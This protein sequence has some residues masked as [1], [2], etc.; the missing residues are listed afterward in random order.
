MKNKEYKLIDLV[1]RGDKHRKEVDPTIIVSDGNSKRGV[2]LDYNTLIDKINLDG[3][4]S[5]NIEFKTSGN[6]N[7]VSDV[8]KDDTTVTLIKSIVALTK[9]DL[10]GYATEKWVESKKY[11][12]SHQDLSEYAKTSEVDSKISTAKSDLIG[13]APATYDTLKEIADYIEKHKE[14]EIALN[15]AIGNKADKT[16][17]EDMATRS[18]VE[19]KQY[20]TQH[21]SLDNYLTK[22]DAS[23]IYL[24]L[25]GGTMTETLYTKTNF[26]VYSGSASSKQSAYMRF[27]RDGAKGSDYV[28]IGNNGNNFRI[29]AKGGNAGYEEENDLLLIGNNKQLKLQ[30]PNGTAP[31]TTS[32]TTLVSNLNADMVDDMHRNIWTETTDSDSTPSSYLSSFKNYLIVANQTTDS[33]GD[34]PGGG[35]ALNVYGGA[36]NRFFR[37]MSDRG[38]GNLYFQTTQKDEGVW[39]ERRT[40]AFTDSTVSAANKL[41]TPRTL[42]GQSFDGS[43]NV[44]GSLTGV[45]DIS[46]S[47]GNKVLRMGSDHIIFGGMGTSATDVVKSMT[48]RANGINIQAKL[49]RYDIYVDPETGNVGMGTSSSAQKLHVA[50]DIYATGNV[51]VNNSISFSRGTDNRG[52]EITKN[53]V[54]RL[55]SSETAGYTMGCIV[56]DTGNTKNLGYAFGA[57]GDANSLK[58]IFFGGTAYNDTAMVI[59]PDKNVGIGTTSPGYKLHVVGD[60]Y[61]PNKV[62]VGDMDLKAEIEAFKAEI[63]ELKAKLS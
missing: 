8:S 52:I 47:S 59:T 18:W 53:G 12:T 45:G 39:R 24:P 5:S 26:E 3:S 4:V 63:A 19:A 60:I 55:I 48:I 61:T 38:S 17:I 32:S 6:G 21:Q 43:G 36:N 23:N 20:L 27:T 10:T 31:I 54:I 57:Y 40:V 49:G 28:A 30:A 42:W 11:L 56:R 44:S 22:T 29:C 9:D 34:I 13:G 7:V 37:L 25:S 58:Y 41:A 16:S 14:V 35:V 15:A 33:F 46:D 51:I 62:L 1:S 2:I 50:G